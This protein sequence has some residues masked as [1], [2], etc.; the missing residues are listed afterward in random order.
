[1]KGT[2]IVVK[3]GDKYGDWEILKEVKGKFGR[4]FLCKN[5]RGLEKEVN[6]VHLRTG[7]SSGYYGFGEKSPTRTHG[8]THTR[9]WQIWM[10]MKARCTFEKEPAYKNYGGR[11][12][13]V[14]S[15]WLKFENFYSDMKDGYDSQM[16]IERID[17]NGNYC[18]A[19]CKWV[20]KA[21]QARNKRNH[22][23]V[24]F[25]GKTYKLFELANLTGVPYQTLYARIFTYKIP[26]EIAV[27][28]KKVTRNTGKP[29]NK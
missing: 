12:I 7:K 22:A 16:T 21:E 13:K 26:I 25:E 4:R 23:E 9:I 6:L 28:K 18:K 20:T 15:E 2:K 3:K 10:G 8:M 1:M 11:G 27:L 19:N 17:V 5:S 24:I 29:K 14:A